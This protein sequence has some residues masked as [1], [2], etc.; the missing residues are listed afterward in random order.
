MRSIL[1]NLLSNAIKYSPQGGK[2]HLALFCNQA[3]AI[4]QI[5]DQGIGIP[6]EDQTHLFELFHR[7]KNVASIPGTGLGLSVVKKC[8]DLQKGQLSI[9]SQVGVGTTVTVTIPLASTC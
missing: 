2:I 6:L 3:E 4:F 5:Q 7:G 9:N 8:L 1:T